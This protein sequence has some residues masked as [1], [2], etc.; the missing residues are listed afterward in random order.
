MGAYQ[1]VST[2]A[3]LDLKVGL[4]FRAKGLGGLSTDSKH[5]Q[6]EYISFPLGLLIAHALGGAG[7]F[8]VRARV[9]DSGF[10]VLWVYGVGS[11]V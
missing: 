6:N 2:I 5:I 1:G 3:H 10:R 8:E 11:S 7:A 9:Y 4:G